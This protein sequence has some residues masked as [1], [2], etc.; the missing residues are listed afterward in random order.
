[1]KKLFLIMALGV[2]SLTCSA[3]IEEVVLTP[4][5][6]GEAPQV[7]LDSIKRAFPNTISQT[8]STI[9][10]NS[11]G[12][13]WN[14]YISPASE[15]ITPLYYYVFLKGKNG[16]QTLIYDKE[17]H[18]L[19]VKQVLKN[20]DV[21]EPVKNTLNTKYAGWAIVGDEERITNANG[22]SGI[23]YKVILKKHGIK[24]AVF[25]GPE[26]DVKVAVPKV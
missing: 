5:K 11:Y 16:N 17:G 22:K 25:I 20:I 18:L 13:A 21:P 3:Q 1:M 26:G 14:V 9:T 24:K 15:E 8:I 12:K 7:L 2:L 23:E 4:V 10:A 6:N 19:K